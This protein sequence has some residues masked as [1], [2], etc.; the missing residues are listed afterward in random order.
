MPSPTGHFTSPAS[1][2]HSTDT[3]D[4]ETCAFQ[5]PCL[6][7]G[8]SSR[9]GR[10]ESRHLAGQTTFFGP[11]HGGDMVGWFVKTPGSPTKHVSFFKGM[12]RCM[13]TN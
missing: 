5:L 2:T 1:L 4:G 12:V 9:L 3:G 8:S 10:T 11:G 7:L 6:G 13:D